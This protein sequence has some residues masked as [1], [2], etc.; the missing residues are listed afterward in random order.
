MHSISKMYF[1]LFFNIVILCV[2]F[3]TFK[4][5]NPDEKSS[6]GS[7]DRAQFIEKEGGCSTNEIQINSGE[8]HWGKNKK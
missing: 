2:N 4:G 7:S 1:I 3:W 6:Q 8:N 5:T